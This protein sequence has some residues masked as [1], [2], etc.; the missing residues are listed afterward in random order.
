MSESEPD[1]DAQGRSSYLA[2]IAVIVGIGL[3][4][5]LA[6]AFIDWNKTQ[7]CVGYGKRDCAPRIELNKQ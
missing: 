4:Y 2:I 6:S 3:L 7:E 1:D 5:W